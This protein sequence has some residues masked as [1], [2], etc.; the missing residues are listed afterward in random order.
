[1]CSELLTLFLTMLLSPT[2]AVSDEIQVTPAGHSYAPA[3][4][5]ADDGRIWM[6]WK[7]FN[8][9]SETTSI[10]VNSYQN[11]ELSTEMRLT[12]A[13]GDVHAPS[14]AVA[15]NSDLWIVWSES[16]NGTWDVYTKSLSE[17]DLSEEICVTNDGKSF[18]ST[19]ALGKNGELWVTWQSK[20]DGN[21]KIFAKRYFEGEWSQD[22]CISEN[23]SSN[24]KPAIAVDGKNDVWIAW[25]SFKNG[26]YDIYLGH[27]DEVE[28]EWREPI[29][30]TTSMKY[31]M[32]ASLAVDSEDE[33]W[34][35]W[36]RSPLWGRE[37]YRL[38]VGKRLMLRKY[39]PTKRQFLQPKSNLRDLDSMVPIPVDAKGR[40]IPITPKIIIDKNDA[41]HILY[42]QFR[43]KGSNDWGWNVEMI[44]YSDTEWSEVTKISSE[45]GFPISEV[46][47]T[48]DRNGALWVAYQACGYL[49]GR[50]PLNDAKSNIYIRRISFGELDSPVLTGAVLPLRKHLEDFEVERPD[51]KQKSVEFNGKKYK[52]LWGELHRHT[53]L[54]KCVSERDGTLWDH[55]R[56]AQDV[57]NL[58]FYATTDHTEQTSSYETRRG[59]LWSDLFYVE[60]DFVTLYGCE[61]NFKDAEHTNFFYINSSIGEFVRAARLTNANLTDAFKMLDTKDLREKV[62]IV[63]HF[64]GD[65]FGKKYETAPP[66][67]PDYEK[68]IEAVQTRGFSPTTVGHYLSSGAKAGLVGGSDHSRAPGGHGGPWVYPYALTGLWA[69][70]SS[71]EAVFNAL[72]KRRCF[73]TNSKKICIKFNSDDHFMGEQYET[74]RV[75]VLKIHVVGTTN[76]WKIELIRNG[77]IIMSKNGTGKTMTV[78]YR[79]EQIPPGDYYY[80]VR[81]IQKRENDDNYR[82]MAI[83]SPIWITVK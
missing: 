56:W 5:L 32:T 23:R 64:H 21:F 38:N 47:A 37:D 83:T 3:I 41:I 49:G 63:R 15:R 65:G 62:L 72:L 53:T 35:A 24:R 58:D 52:L 70:E 57:A 22:Y 4:A 1:M 10:L 31:D 33:I 26:N 2:S 13:S 36:T 82:G 73:A 75:P 69:E 80:Y 51:H 29:R 12:S 44:S 81:V 66:L 8:T 40:V 30:V 11:D 60:D 48:L 55:Y 77:E 18:N 79:D 46:A 19:V 78:K 34:V 42:R 7:A 71:R 76:L 39:A 6:A 74:E 17:G 59:Q 61:Q 14:L 54:S 50:K 67:H 43:D 45:P 28:N 16:C 25:D 27:F 9:E 68:V 20:R